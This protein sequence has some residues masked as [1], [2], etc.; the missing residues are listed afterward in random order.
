[1]FLVIKD[2]AVIIAGETLQEVIQE[3]QDQEIP[4]PYEILHEIVK[5]CAACNGAK[6]LQEFDVR[7]T[8]GVCNGTGKARFYSN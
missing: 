6:E 8:C 4:L 1:M 5:Y 7:F 3:I 2:G